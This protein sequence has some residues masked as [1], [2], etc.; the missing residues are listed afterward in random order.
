M[1]TLRLRSVPR[2]FLRLSLAGVL[3]L[4]NAADP[5]DETQPEQVLVTEGRYAQ[6]AT[7]TLEAILDIPRNMQVVPANSSRTV[8]SMIRRMGFKM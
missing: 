7:R 3:V 2:I 6:S 1:G 4:A 5:S 8:P